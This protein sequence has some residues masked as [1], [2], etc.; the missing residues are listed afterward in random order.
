MIDRRAAVFFFSLNCDTLKIES[1]L[2]VTNV[3]G[4]LVMMQTLE[5]N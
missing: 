2:Q 4:K 5:S 3:K 1:E